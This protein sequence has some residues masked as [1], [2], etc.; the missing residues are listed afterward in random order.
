VQ[1]KLNGYSVPVCD[2]AEV[3]SSDPLEFWHKQASFTGIIYRAFVSIKCLTED[4]VNLG[5]IPNKSS[6]VAEIGD[7]GHNRHGPK[8]EGV[9][10]PFRGALGT[11]PIQC[12]LRR[13]LLPYQVVTSSIQPYATIV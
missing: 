13:Y 1:P 3:F 2:K 11:R 12:G 9:L 10:C 6:A 4:S 8:R 7:R 5:D